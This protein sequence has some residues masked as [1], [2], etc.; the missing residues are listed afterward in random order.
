MGRLCTWIQKVV[1]EK[2]RSCGGIPG[3]QCL[4]MRC[5]PSMFQGLEEM[6]CWRSFSLVNLNRK[7]FWPRDAIDSPW[8]CFHAFCMIAIILL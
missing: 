2:S 4:R 8:V 7:V 3:I 1:V 6:V 5:F